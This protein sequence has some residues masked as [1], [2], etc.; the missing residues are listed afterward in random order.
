M[1]NSQDIFEL[2]FKEG[3][4]SIQQHFVPSHTIYRI[5]FSD[6]RDPLVV[7]GCLPMMLPGGGHLY[8][9]AGKEK[10]KKSGH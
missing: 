5:V 3:K 4:I 6:K 10:R 8:L 1:E 9:K 7:T 2:G